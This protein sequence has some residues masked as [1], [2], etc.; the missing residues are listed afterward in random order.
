MLQCLERVENEEVKTHIRIFAEHR[1]EDA[2]E[3]Y[4]QF[5]NI[6]FEMEY[7]LKKRTIFS[8]F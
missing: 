4:H 3:I 5:D 2:E 6:R 7:P 1:D 8:K